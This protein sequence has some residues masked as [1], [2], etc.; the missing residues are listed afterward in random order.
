MHSLTHILTPFPYLFSL[1]LIQLLLS[2]LQLFLS[3]SQASFCSLSDY[4]CCS[5]STKPIQIGIFYSML[6]M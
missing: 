1:F 5:A 3:L 6:L 4:L 2:L